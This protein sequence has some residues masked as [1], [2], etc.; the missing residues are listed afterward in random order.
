MKRKE[1]S[2]TPIRASR[3]CNKAK[4]K[5]EEAESHECCYFDILPSHLT[6]HIFL[7][8]PIKSL[9]ICKCVCKIW[10]AMI[11]EPHFAKLHFERS[12]ISL[13]IRTR[14]YRRVSR[15]LYLLECDPKKFEIGSNNH[16]KLEPIFRLTLRGDV[17]SLRMK[18]KSKHPYIACNRDRDNFSIVNSCN[19]LL[20]LSQPTT[21]NPLV[22]CNPFMGEFIRL[23]EANTVRMPHDTVRVIGQEAGFGFYP[24]TNEYKVIHIWRRSVIRVNSSSDVEHVFLVEIHTLG[25]STWRN[26]NVDPQIS[27]S[28]LMN[29]TCVNGAL[30]WIRFEGKETLQSFPSPPVAFGSHVQDQIDKYD[31]LPSNIH[32]SMGELKGFLYICDSN[33]LKYVTMWVM[34]EYGIGESWTKVYHINTLYN[35]L[36]WRHPLYFP[37]KHFEEGA[38]VLL[39]HSYDRFTYYGLM[40]IESSFFEFM[41]ILKDILK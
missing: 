38:A 26:I 33:S 34:N 17:K 35:P 10:K 15:T 14:Y 11:S 16:V 40:N 36:A 22:I 4:G 31:F 41:G 27:F 13:M 23:P 30:H 5:V 28:C 21:G 25:T 19:G 6:T 29:P 2:I 24:T 32:I 1:G 3:R 18:Y 12:P 8:L 39:H 7:Q 9:L 20:C 37:V